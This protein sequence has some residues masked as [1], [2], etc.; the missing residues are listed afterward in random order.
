MRITADTGPIFE[1]DTDIDIWE[2][3]KMKI[4]IYK[5]IFVFLMLTHNNFVKDPLNVIIKQ[6]WPN[7][8]SGIFHNWNI[9]L[10]SKLVY[11]SIDTI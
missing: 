10:K 11:K 9:H 1:S 5:L 4:T 6:L 8:L 7:Y 3:K 2:F